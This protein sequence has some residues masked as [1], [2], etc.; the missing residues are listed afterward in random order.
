VSS[1]YVVPDGDRQVRVAVAADAK[2]TWAFFDGHVWQIDQAPS[3]GGRPGKGRGESGV[4][5]PMPATVVAI[6]TAPGRTVNEGDTVIV[7]EAMKME[8]PIK[9]PR[10]GVVK[11]VNCAKGELV[12]PGVNLLELEP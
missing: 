10:S 9:A 7:L 3:G 5:A 1:W 8:L 11:A 12:Q 2:Y 4:M 6:N